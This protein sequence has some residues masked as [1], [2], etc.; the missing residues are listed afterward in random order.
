[1]YEVSQF[2]EI[3]ILVVLSFKKRKENVQKLT[4]KYP[5]LVFREIERQVR[6][7]SSF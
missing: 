1:M 3:S 6:I 4:L 2:L 7:S 5:E